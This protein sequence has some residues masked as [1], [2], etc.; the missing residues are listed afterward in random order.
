M[1][2]K[3]IIFDA[4]GMAIHNTIWFSKH[5]AKEYGIKEE[6]LLPFFQ[7]EFQDCLVGKAG[8]KEEL[9]KYI[10][11]WG[12]QGTIDELLA[13]WFKSEDNPDERVLLF[14]K[15]LQA[16]GL[17]CSL[18]TNNEKYRTNYMIEQM[19]FGK[20]FEKIYSSA[21]MGFK[22][23]QAEF[24]NYIINDIGLKKDEVVFWDDEANLV[25][26]VKKQGF[27]TEKYTDFDSFKNKLKSLA[28]I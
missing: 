10:T 16:K 21:F 11:L 14:V 25:E 9:K 5:L 19:G 1:N 4:D 17:I 8:L 28:L 18:S 24:Y 2:I 27:K 13:I 26:E 6:L 3:A 23:P 7:N 15:E 12:W 22:K 20:V